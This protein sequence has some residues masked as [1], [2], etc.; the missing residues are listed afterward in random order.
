VSARRSDQSDFWQTVSIY[1]GLGFVLFGSIGGGYLLGWL[2]DRWLG[3]A[4]IFALIVAGLGLAGGLIKILQ[5]LKR[6]EKRESGNN[7]GSSGN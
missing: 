5:I 6:V 1:S 2:L 7:N 4:P 3:T